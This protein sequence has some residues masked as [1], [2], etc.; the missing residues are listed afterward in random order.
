METRYNGKEEIYFSIYIGGNWV[1]APFKKQ[2]QKK[3]QCIISFLRVNWSDDIYGHS[4][5]QHLF[6]KVYNSVEHFDYEKTEALVL[7][8][9]NVSRISAM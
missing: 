2:L 8:S 1:I 7:S 6:V 5:S 4:Y 3:T 9:G